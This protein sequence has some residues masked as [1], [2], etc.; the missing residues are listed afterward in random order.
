M[1]HVIIIE[2]A[3]GEDGLTPRP[4]PEW[5]QEFIK[6]LID[7]QISTKHGACV[8]R[9]QFNVQSAIA[10]VHEMYGAPAWDPTDIPRVY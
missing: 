2:T 9:S 1:K 4:I 5:L 7:G 10:A 8:I 3:D 6:K